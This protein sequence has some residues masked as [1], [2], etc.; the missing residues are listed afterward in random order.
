[1]GKR[2]AFCICITAL[3]G[4]G[5]AQQSANAI[6][7][8]PA[9]LTQAEHSRSWMLPE[10]KNND[11]LYV[12]TFNGSALQVD[13]YSWPRAKPVGTL[14]GVA[15]SMC[16]DSDGNIWITNFDSDTIVGYAHG[17]TTPIATLKIPRELHLGVSSCAIDPTSGNLAVGTNPASGT[18]ASVL[19]YAG[20]RGR[21]KIYHVL[22]ET[23]SLCTYD[24][25]GNLFVYGYAYGPSWFRLSSVLELQKGATSFRGISFPPA[26]LGYE[27]R[28]LQWDGRYLVIGSQ[29]PTLERYEVSQFTAVHKDSVP[30]D[31]LHEVGDA[32]IQRG[33]GRSKQFQWEWSVRSNLQLPRR[34]Q[35]H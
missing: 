4:C 24:N 10:A 17:G 6:P 28:S 15:G 27:P 32:W 9:A 34:R 20:A 30:F 25:D 5:G 33:E 23:S 26:R 19:V 7:Q 2:L 14:S 18:I 3:A 21:P 8:G 13:V 11:L 16:P 31:D 29:P 22:L 35:P 1:M 12:S